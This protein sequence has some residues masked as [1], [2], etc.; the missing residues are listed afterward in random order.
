MGLGKRDRHNKETHPASGAASSRPSLA[1]DKAAVEPKSAAPPPLRACA[2]PVPTEELPHALTFFVT[3]AQRR[4]VLVR[5]RA[6]HARRVEAL[7]Q[8]LGIEHV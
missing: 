6:L 8:A 3:A 4:A 2:A 5:L 1:L 7:L